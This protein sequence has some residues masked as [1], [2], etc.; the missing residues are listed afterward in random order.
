MLD[1]I[2]SKNTASFIVRW[3]LGLLFTMAGWWKMFDLGATAHA[4][5]FFIEGFAEHWIPEWL[6]WTLG[7]TIPYLELAA[8]LMLLVGVK[9]NWAL[10]VLGLLL[11]VTT[12][13]HALQE[14]LFNIDGHTFTR[15]ALIVFLLLVGSR[16]DRLTVDYWFE[17]RHAGF[18]EN[19]VSS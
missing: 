1:S 9:I 4:Q 13:G 12:Y 15:L 6:L 16:G 3:I 18:S 5:R 14:P 2:A 11:I 8:G 17:R 7:V 10:T 19:Q